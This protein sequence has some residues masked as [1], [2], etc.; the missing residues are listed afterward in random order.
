MS[1]A[2]SEFAS[3][4]A[5][6]EQPTLTLLYRPHAPVTVTVFRSFF[7]RDTTSV[8]AARLHQLVQD[9]LDVLRSAGVENV[10][11]GTGRELCQRWVKD[12]WLFRVPDPQSDSEMYTLTSAAQTAL[13]LVDELSRSRTTLSEHR[14]ATILD[15]V[16]SFNVRANPSREARLQLLDEQIAA[17]V[18]ERDRLQ[19]GGDLPELSPEFMLEGYVEILALVAALP[20]DF[21][22]VQ[23]AF[24][25]IRKQI[26]AEFRTEERPAGAVIDNYLRRADE[27]ISAT[28]EGRAFSGAL[29]LLRNDDLRAQLRRDLAALLTH[30]MA[31]DILAEEDRR[32]LRSTMAFINRGIEDVLAQRARAT[33]A[34]KDYVQ[35]HDVARDRELN[36]TLRQLDHEFGQWLQTSGPRSRV[37]VPL[38]PETH[39]LD[40][41]PRRMF[42]PTPERQ[43]APLVDP[44]DEDDD[45][46]PSLDQMLAW[47]GPSLDALRSVLDDPPQDAATLGQLFERLPGELRRPVE[48]FG[49]LHLIE[50]TS[51]AVE[52]DGV[53]ELSAVRA[54]GSTRR[55]TVPRVD[56][57][58]HDDGGPGA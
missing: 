38:L 48:I 22:R 39:E 2:L 40:Y 41:L 9:L 7:S 32:E 15:A 47:G 26:L 10:P 5:A 14:I 42:D 8:A 31:P 20:S 53:E 27:L 57:P 30:P 4:R 21:V 54:D 6:F 33:R 56:L 1:E 46:G 36:A 51:G 49:L 12:S 45:D 29:N 13:A 24:E 11:S 3:V 52:R 16:R 58:P 17:L 28:P 25:S 34:I 55:F 50:N 18:E 19:G 43:P 44:D 35:T 23:E 37:P